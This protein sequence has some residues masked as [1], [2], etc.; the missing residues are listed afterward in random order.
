MFYQGD[1]GQ[2]GSSMQGRGCAQCHQRKVCLPTA[3][4]CGAREAARSGETLGRKETSL[5]SGP[6]SDATTLPRVML[7]GDAI[8]IS[9]PSR[10]VVTEP[11]PPWHQGAGRC[12]H[13]HS[14]RPGP[15]SPRWSQAP[16]SIPLPWQPLGTR[17]A[18]SSRAEAAAGGRGAMATR[19]GWGLPWRRE[20]QH[21]ERLLGEGCSSICQHP[22]TEVDSVA[23]NTAACAPWLCAAPARTNPAGFSQGLVL[24]TTISPG[25]RLAATLPPR[26]APSTSRAGPFPPCRKRGGA[27][28][29]ACA[30]KAGSR[31]PAAIPAPELA[32]GL[33]LLSLLPTFC[34]GRSDLSANVCG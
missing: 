33:R 22:D 12:L 28:P 4:T 25:A 27:A 15:G 5:G 31:A 16:Q 2:R 30:G 3:T 17:K 24:R 6:Q 14:P 10:W 23:G 19:R 20:A 32:A 1:S 26:D 18:G 13:A 29:P 9:P 8:P 11:V 21:P 34:A 7:P